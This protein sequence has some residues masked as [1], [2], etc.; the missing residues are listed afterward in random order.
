MMY[1]NTID[2]MPPS[3]RCIMNKLLLF[4]NN[5]VVF[6]DVDFIAIYLMESD[7]DEF[8]LLKHLLRKY[9]LV[10][11]NDHLSNHLL[12]EIPHHAKRF[13][14]MGLKLD[15]LNEQMYDCA[16]YCYYNLESYGNDDFALNK[17]REIEREERMRIY[18][19]A[20]EVVEEIGKTV[21][22][23]E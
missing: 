23:V 22:R 10:C 7:R 16:N 13:R 11:L 12:K 5:C 4:K 3:L 21:E 15:M 9:G 19:I 20:M 18:G 8:T 2:V 17:F 6:D 1:V 14:I